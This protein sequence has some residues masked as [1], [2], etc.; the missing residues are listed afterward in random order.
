[1]HKFRRMKKIEQERNI[2]PDKD[3]FDNIETAYT[4]AMYTYMRTLYNNQTL[5]DNE[6]LY[7]ALFV[8]LRNYAY[9][10]MF[11]Y[12]DK[13]EFNVPYGGMSYNHKL[14][15]TKM[16]YYTSE[17]LL[18]H[19]QRTVIE[20]H[21]FE[22]FFNIYKPTENDFVF[23]DPPYDSDF[24]TYAQNEF[25]KEDQ[26]RL[27]EYLCDKCHAKWLLIIKYTPYIFSLYNRKGIEI[28]K[29]DKKYIVSFMNRNDKDVEHL[30]ITNYKNQYD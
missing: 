7:T 20:N 25:T 17:G 23:L 4:S 3:I 21:D 6:F 18:R 1:M 19:L 11:R 12:N 13:G 10:G 14:L 5:R 15:T 8:F 9:S 26:K 2:M 27:A 24:S 29:F 28:R 16:A 30:I 22:E